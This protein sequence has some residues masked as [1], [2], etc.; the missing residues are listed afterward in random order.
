MF[1]P[2]DNVPAEELASRIAKLQGALAASDVDAALILPPA[3][4]Y[5]FAGTVQDAFLVVSREGEALFLVRRS[6]ERATQESSLCRILPLETS[7]DV[8]AILRREGLGP[9]RRLGLALDLFPVLTGNRIAQLFPDAELVDISAAIRQIR[10]VKSPWEVELIRKA[11]AIQDRMVQRAIQVLREGMLEVELAAEV[12]AEGRRLGHTGIMRY[13]RFGQETFFGQIMAGP[14]AA[15]P[16]YLEA[17]TGGPGLGPALGNG[18]GWR[19]IATHEPI[20]FD[21][22]GAWAGYISDQARTL[23]IG[24]LGEEWVKAYDAVVGIREEALARL[25]PGNAA[26]EVYEAARAGA[27]RLG[28]GDF[29]MNHGKAQ[30][31][32]VGH[33]VG[34]EVDELPALARGVRMTLEPGMVVAVEPK[35][36]FP[37]RGAVGLEDTFLVTDGGPEP[38]TFTRRDLIIIE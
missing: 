15:A 34:I 24:T 22:P 23:S 17:P 6:F 5:Y 18:A 16:C 36:V 26:G 3:D 14:S 4:L 8:P 9:F 10:A 21:M 28:Y 2:P 12:E 25:R 27:A 7:K 31:R 13:R 32:Y 11:A 29:F 33:G 38:L 19:R 35:I 37:G 30:V 20:L 1:D